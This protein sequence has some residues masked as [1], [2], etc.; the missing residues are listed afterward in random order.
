MPSACGAPPPMPK[1]CSTPA[2]GRCST[3]WR[4][5][6][7]ACTAWRRSIPSSARWR[8]SSTRCDRCWR[9]RRLRAGAR[10]R[11]ISAD[12]ERLEQIEERIAVLQR[13]ARKYACAPAELAA[14][15]AG[16]EQALAELADGGVDPAELEAAGRR[17]PPTRRGR[18]RT[19]CRGARAQAA[20]ALGERITAGLRELALGGARIELELEP[21]TPGAA[22]PAAPR[23][24]RPR[25]DRHRDRAGR[26]ALRG[27]SGRDAAS[28]RQGRLR[29]RALAHHV[30]DQGGDRR[31][32]RRADAR[33]STRSTPASAARW[34]RPSVASSPRSRPAAKSSASRTCRRSPPAPTIISWCASAPSKA[35]AALPPIAC[36][37][38]E[39]VEELARMLAGV[40]VTKEARRHAAE[41]RR[42]GRGRRSR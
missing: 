15:R 40:T 4:A 32:D 9:T 33:C 11:A 7:S 1:P 10:A 3:S 25:P 42:L 28:A 17:R 37:T 13:L 8:G 18:R 14:R 20:P 22:T 5:P 27:Q 34:R 16:L 41:L 39:R 23:A 19:R 36:P 21:T 12:P 26:L 31:R 2:T 24:R 30:G 6:P 35:A 29:G 38:P